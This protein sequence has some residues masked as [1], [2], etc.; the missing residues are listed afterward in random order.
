NDPWVHASLGLVLAAH[1]H[2]PAAR[3]LGN[4]VIDVLRDVGLVV[5]QEAA[6]A[7]AEVLH[8]DGV[9][10]QVDVATVGHLDM[11]E[12]EIPLRMQPERDAMGHVVGFAVPYE[13]VRASAAA[14]AG[15]RPDRLRDKGSGAADAQV[16]PE[17]A[18]VVRRAQHL[19]E[20][21][22][23][24][25]ALMFDRERAAVRQQADR[26]TTCIADLA[27]AEIGVAGCTAGWSWRHL[28]S[29]VSDDPR[30]GS[31]RR[32]AQ[33]FRQCGWGGRDRTSEWR[34]QNPLKPEVFRHLHACCRNLVASI[35]PMS[36][37]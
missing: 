13:A 29:P 21:D 12:P 26:E 8:E 31:R 14:N 20:H 7:E 3:V 35:P 25:V 36:Q 16:E 15:A 4:V 37:R 1:D 10:R 24:A 6:A 30:G 11:P 17:D 2:W 27:E 23:V 18:A 22:P 33:G 19:V 34:N 5:H 28:R 9:A 32:L